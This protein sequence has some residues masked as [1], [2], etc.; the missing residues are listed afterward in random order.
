[1]ARPRTE[2]RMAEAGMVFL[3][4]GTASFFS[5]LLQFCAERTVKT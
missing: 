2:A 4:G 5:A 3:G 1:M